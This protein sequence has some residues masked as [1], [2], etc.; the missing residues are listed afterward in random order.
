MQTYKI[1]KNES[2]YLNVNE[3]TKPNKIFIK[4]ETFHEYKKVLRGKGGVFVFHLLSHL[5]QTFSL[6]GS[7]K[8]LLRNLGIL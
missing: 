7:R 1:Y 4:K 8:D 6:P 3:I 2:L 5:K